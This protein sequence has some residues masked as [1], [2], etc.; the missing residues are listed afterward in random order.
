MLIAALFSSMWQKVSGAEAWIFLSI[1][2]V[3]LAKI[4]AICDFTEMTYKSN[5][6]LFKE[7]LDE[8]HN[9]HNVKYSDDWYDEFWFNKKWIHK[10]TWTEYDKHWFNRDARVTLKN[11]WRK[12]DK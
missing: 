4:I 5:P 10:D 9:Y 3:I 6:F 1:I 12:P 8:Y 7:Y 2:L 11:A